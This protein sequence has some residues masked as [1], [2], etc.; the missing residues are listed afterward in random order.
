[1]QQVE[2]VHAAII[3]ARRVRLLAAATAA[4]ALVLAAPAAAAPPRHGVLV[5]GRS[6]GGVRLGTPM[7]AVIARWGRGFGVCRGCRATT[8]YYT[9]ERFQPQGVAVSFRKGR[10]EALFTLW[11]PSGWRTSLGIVIGDDAAQVTAV[12]GALDRR[13]CTGY[14]TLILHTRAGV[15]EFYVV[16]DRLWGFGVSRAPQPCR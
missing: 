14:S 2:D 6:L 16:G 12:Y 13:D 7:Q 4:A 15:T 5:P 1:V 9:Y 11:Q 8:W 10:A 3:Y